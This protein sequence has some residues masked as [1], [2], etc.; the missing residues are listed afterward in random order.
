MKKIKETIGETAFA[1]FERFMKRLV[2]VPKDKVVPKKLSRE[3]K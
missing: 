3:V 1:R 2:A